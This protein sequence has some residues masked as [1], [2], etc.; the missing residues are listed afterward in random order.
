MP[1]T[2]AVEDKEY[3]MYSWQGRVY[4]T[5]E[6]APKAEAV[7]C[8]ILPHMVDFFVDQGGGWGPRLWVWSLT[9]FLYIWVRDGK[10]NP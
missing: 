6:V 9:K 3:S 7:L 2:P 10:R 4:D 8:S 5:H 1:P